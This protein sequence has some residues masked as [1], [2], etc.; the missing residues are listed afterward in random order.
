MAGIADIFM[1]WFCSILTFLSAVFPGTL[2]THSCD[3]CKVCEHKGGIST[4]IELAI[5]EKCGNEYGNYSDHFYSEYDEVYPDCLN[6][7]YKTF[8]CN[9][10]GKTYDEKTYDELGHNWTDWKVTREATCEKSGQMRRICK[11]DQCEAFETKPIDKLEH[12]YTGDE[13]QWDSSTNSHRQICVNG[14]GEYGNLTKCTFY[15]IVKEDGVYNVCSG[16]GYEE[17]VQ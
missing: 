2:G 4:C 17:V 16:C 5:C 1:K 12:S 11:R 9:G 7:G 14:C 6:E 3:V 15:K 13:Y 8:I 10:C